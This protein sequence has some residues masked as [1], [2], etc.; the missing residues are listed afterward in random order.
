[1]NDEHHPGIL[2]ICRMTSQL[3]GLKAT[4]YY[5]M[6]NAV[7]F[8]LNIINNNF[9]LNCFKAFCLSSVERTMECNVIFVQ[10]NTT[11]ERE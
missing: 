6:I 9:V 1:M 3:T 11:E 8:D 7:E 4:L 2:G 5:R 10:D